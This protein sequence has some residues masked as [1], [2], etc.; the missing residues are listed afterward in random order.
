MS[1]SPF[2]CPRSRSPGFCPS[3]RPILQLISRR[4]ST[5]TPFSLSSPARTPGSA[6]SGDCP[7]SPWCRYSLPLPYPASPPPGGGPRRGQ[8]GWLDGPWCCPEPCRGRVFP[9][10]GVWHGTHGLPQQRARNSPGRRRAPTVAA[11]ERLAHRAAS[12][13][14]YQGDAR[15]LGGWMRDRSRM[16]ATPGGWFRDRVGG[17][18]GYVRLR[19]QS[20][21]CFRIGWRDHGLEAGHRIAGNV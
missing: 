15:P 11:Q 19:L 4:P 17:R 8:I 10:V 21:D 5:R 2:P 18:L 6:F 16:S 20:P 7:W 9:W 3:V 1:P 12:K 13:P 14:L